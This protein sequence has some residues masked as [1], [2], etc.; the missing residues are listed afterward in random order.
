MYKK[1]ALRI[2]NILKRKYTI[3][4]TQS[5][6]SEMVDICSKRGLVSGRVSY[7]ALILILIE[8]ISQ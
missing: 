3:Y 5:Q 7:K 2:V 1:W 8:K 4:K 6:F